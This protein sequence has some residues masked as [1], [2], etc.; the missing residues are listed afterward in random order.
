[1][2]QVRHSL[3]RENEKERISN[4]KVLIVYFVYLDDTWNTSSF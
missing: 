2:I 3:D 4:M 1:M